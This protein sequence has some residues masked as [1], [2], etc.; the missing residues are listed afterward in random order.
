M[1]AH[2]ERAT[3]AA[4]KQRYAAVDMPM[5]EALAFITAAT[6]DLVTPFVHSLGAGPGPKL[7]Q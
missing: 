6:P 7:A 5:A 4:G 2:G 3:T 1:S